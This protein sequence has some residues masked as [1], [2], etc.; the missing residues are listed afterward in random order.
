MGDSE[1]IELKGMTHGWVV[2]PV[3]PLTLIVSD[4]AAGFR[5]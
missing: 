5:T 1:L 3:S 4:I 2:I